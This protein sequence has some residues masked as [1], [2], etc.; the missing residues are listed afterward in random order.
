[1]FGF[2]I[3]RAERSTKQ[4][5]QYNKI[6]LHRRR[7]RSCIN[8]ILLNQLKMALFWFFLYV[9][10][11]IQTNTSLWIKEVQFGKIH[12]LLNAHKDAIHLGLP[13]VR[14]S[15]ALKLRSKW[16]KKKQRIIIYAVMVKRSIRIRENDYRTTNRIRSNEFFSLPLITCVTTI[17]HSIQR[18]HI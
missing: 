1:M 9:K 7:R 4:R 8:F 16:R 17:V 5:R 11:C 12:L 2:T 10:R 6:I 13:D 3:S 18:I 15:D 14:L